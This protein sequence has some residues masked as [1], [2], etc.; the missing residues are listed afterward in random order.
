MVANEAPYIL[1]DWNKANQNLEKVVDNFA[2][3]QPRNATKSNRLQVA[4]E[5]ALVSLLN[6]P[7]KKPFYCCRLVLLLLAKQP[8]ETLM[9]FRNNEDEHPKDLRIVIQNLLA[10][11]KKKVYLDILRLIP[12]SNGQ[13]IAPSHPDIPLTKELTISVHNIPTRHEDIK[14]AMIHTAQLYYDLGVLEISK[15][16][17]K[18]KGDGA[19]PTTQTV[20]LYHP[21]GVKLQHMLA[22]RAPRK[23]VPIYDAR[24]LE[25]QIIHLIYSRRKTGWCTCTHVV[26]PT[27]V[28]LRFGQVVITDAP[29]EAYLSMTLQGSVSYLMTPELSQTTGSSKEWSHML[30]AHEGVIYLHCYDVHLETAFAKMKSE[31]IDT[32]KVKLEDLFVPTSFGS[33][34]ETEFFETMVQPNCFPD[35]DALLAANN[36]HLTQFNPFQFSRKRTFEKLLEDNKVLITRKP[37]EKASRWRT[38]FRDCMGTDLFG[39]TLNDDRSISDYALDVL[40]GVP[41]HSGYG[42]TVVWSPELRQICSYILSELQDNTASKGKEV[43]QEDTVT[44]TENM[45]VDVA[46]NQAM[47]YKNMTLREQEEVIKSDIAETAVKSVPRLSRRPDVRAEINPNFRG[48]RPMSLPM[49]KK[50]LYPDPSVMKPYLEFVR[51]TTEQKRRREAKGMG[52]KGSLIWL[53]Q[54]A[55]KEA[56]QGAREEGED[57]DGKGLVVRNGQCKRAKREFDS[58]Q[59]A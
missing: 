59:P 53:Y 42:I 24:Y 10:N 31:T 49:E 9:T 20:T 19:Q 29:T 8:D 40:N 3:A 32:A 4:L 45:A 1:N 55:E 27:N 12:V 16:P 36:G 58:Q 52:P 33:S 26:T 48:R 34:E 17:M 43:E 51:P 30:M 2:A 6:E 7:N 11:A 56:K 25:N 15:I 23:D 39:V 28:G 50:S 35:L 38:C 47:R 14:R 54:M 57:W 21:I 41:K 46:W 18:S 44:M 5:K 22:K 37:M 13:S